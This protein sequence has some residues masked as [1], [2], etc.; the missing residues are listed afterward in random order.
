M[1]IAGTNPLL[2]MTIIPFPGFSPEAAACWDSVPPAFQEQILAHVFCTNCRKGVPIVG[3]SGSMLA[4]DLLLKGRCGVCGHEVA[5]LLEGPFSDPEIPFGTTFREPTD[6]YYLMRITL[7]DVQ[8]EIWRRFM[9]PGSITLDRLH[10]V[11]QVVM[12]WDDYHVHQF[13]IG[14]TCF[15]E[16]LDPDDP[17]RPLD[18]AGYRLQDLVRRKGRR[19]SYIYDFG[20]Y[21]EH[22][23]TL[24]HSR[25]E[26]R[27]IH[28]PVWCL[29]GEGASP[30]EDVG[31]PEGFSEFSRVMADPR[32]PDHEQFRVWYGERQQP[33]GGFDRA[34]VDILRIN[35]RLVDYQ[36]W[37]R[38]RQLPRGD[39]EI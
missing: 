12:G 26:P 38:D 7:Q 35:D 19:F 11:L 30:P 36:R 1:F 23:L 28:Y 21:W 3:Y 13:T 14:R 2:Q 39:W 34:K 9:V 37:T 29:E 32:H 5:R 24:E 8:P 18:E 31:G 25:F 16:H 27:G 17:G 22:E 15:M 10:D 33:G 20:D 4:G 6:R